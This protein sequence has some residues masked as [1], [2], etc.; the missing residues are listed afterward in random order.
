MKLNQKDRSSMK[1]DISYGTLPT[2]DIVCVESGNELWADDDV[3]AIELKPHPVKKPPIQEYSSVVTDCPELAHE[4]HYQ[5]QAA[6]P[7]HSRSPWKEMDPVLRSYQFRS[8]PREETRESRCWHHITPEVYIILLISMVNKAGQELSVACMPFIMKQ[9]FQCESEGIGYFMALIGGLVMPTNLA[10]NYF[11]KDTEERSMILRLS[12]ISI[13]GICIV[14]Q[15]GMLGH[16]TILQYLLGTAIIFTSLNSLEGVIMSLLSKLISPELAKGT[17]NSGLLATEAGTFGRM[18]GDMAITAFG[19]VP[20]ASTVVNQ[21][22]F[23]LAVM[24]AVTVAS[25]HRY[26]DKLED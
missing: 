8:D 21:L 24:I 15:L 12:Y 19:A 7:Q 26:Y 10:V 14:C 17:F 4:Y 1:S 23:P 11:A 13:A 3:T 22:Y 20:G 2:Q 5:Q 18:M 6:E 16:Y 25:V 9:V